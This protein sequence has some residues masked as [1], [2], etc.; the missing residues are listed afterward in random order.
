M[1]IKV[2]GMKYED[3]IPLV[4]GCR[5]DYMGFIFYPGSKRYAEPLNEQVLAGIPSDIKK[6]GVFV[7]STVNEMDRISNKYGFKMI[8]LHG[9]ESVEEVEQLKGLGYE[10]IKVF[11][12]SDRLDPAV[13]KPYKG[14]ADYFLFDTK[15]PMYGGSGKTYNWGILKDY[16]NEVPF[17][18]SGGIGPDMAEQI[19]ALT[20]LNIHAVDIN[21]CFEKEP[22]L[23]DPQEIE[24]FVL[25]IRGN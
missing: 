21:S 18:L 23:K 8:Q 6:V 17:F 15:T 19:K 20:G 25:K 10:T 14:I 1:K 9:K 22:G 16:D 4:A 11:S 12:V 5:P 3:N 24:N 7:N 2:C 13:Y